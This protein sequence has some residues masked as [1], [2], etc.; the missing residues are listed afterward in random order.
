VSDVIDSGVIEVALDLS[1][2]DKQLANLSN[3]ISESVEQGFSNTGQAASKMASGLQNGVK[4]IGQQLNAAMA[5]VGVAAGG[6][7]AT[8]LYRGY[9]RYTTIEDSLISMET[10]LGSATRAATMLDDVLDVVRGTPFN[11]DQFADAASRMVAFGAEAEKIP[12]YLEAIGEVS[13]TKG[14]RANEFAMRLSTSFG[15][16]AAMGRISNEELNQM[17]QAGVPALRILANEAEVTTVE[18]KEMISQ[19]I[20]PADEAMDTLTKGILEGSNGLAGATPAMAGTMEGLRDTMTGALGGMQSAMARFGAEIVSQL[21]PG[22][23]A[24]F[25]ATAAVW[26]KLTSSIEGFSLDESSLM[27]TIVEFLEK[28]A[29]SD[30]GALDDIFDTLSSISSLAAPLAAMSGAKGLGAIAG[31]IPGLGALVGPLTG[32]IGTLVIGLGALLA[33]NEEFMA[34]LSDMGSQLMD[35]FAPL[36]ETVMGPLVDLM[37]VLSDTLAALIQAAVPLI[38]SLLIVLKPILDIVIDIVGGVLQGLTPAFEMVGA[39]FQRIAP[40]FQKLA[41]S[42]SELAEFAG[43]LITEVMNQ[44]VVQFELMMP[45]AEQLWVLIIELGAALIDMMVAL[46]PIVIELIAIQTEMMSAVLNSKEF[47]AA[48][49]FVTWTV[50]GL[51]KAAKWAAD[52]L[53]WISDKLNLGP[54]EEEVDAMNAAAEATR[55]AAAAQEELADRIG[56]VTEAIGKSLTPTEAWKASL[57]DSALAYKIFQEDLAFMGPSPL[58]ETAPKNFVELADAIDG[59]NLGNMAY[60]LERGE[61][62]LAQLEQQMIDNG[63]PAAEMQFAMDALGSAVGIAAE[64]IDSTDFGARQAEDARAAVNKFNEELVLFLDQ[65]EGIK[66]ASFG[67]AIASEFATGESSMLSMQLAA[68]DTQDV[69]DNF[70]GALEDVGGW[71]PDGTTFDATRDGAR[72]LYEAAI[73]LQQMF[74]EDLMEAYD[75]ANA[76]PLVDGLEAAQAA[77]EEFGAEM[78][79]GL[80]IEEGTAEYE[81]FLGVLGATPKQV[82]TM[83]NVAGEI[84]AEKKL[85]LL[86]DVIGGLPTDIQQ[87]ITAQ[88]MEDDYAGALE[89]AEKAV[90][91]GVDTPIIPLTPEVDEVVE[92]MTAKFLANPP[93]VPVF[94]VE[95]TDQYGEVSV[96]IK[97][98]IGEPQIT[99]R[100]NYVQGNGTNLLDRTTRNMTVGTSDVGAMGV[101]TMSDIDYTITGTGMGRE[102]NMVKIEDAT[103]MDGIDLD[104]L[105]AQVRLGMVLA[106]ESV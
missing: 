9:Q 106:G 86:G 90:A 102:V 13:A 63:V 29:N 3:E 100:L 72:E 44:M 64:E 56:L 51:V 41:D 95:P 88:I 18:M 55:A 78:A 79:A 6:A 5:A 92:E 26:D 60:N 53:G 93:D 36:M 96:A 47:A 38:Q 22:L 48:V 39:M 42:L 54:D 77:A 8:S 17:A 57:E 27:K 45:F 66:S 69:F 20:I 46:A 65:L 104:E 89:T 59:L 37:D 24:V 23:T 32:G 82:E 75:A 16:I 31:F 12:G 103:F 99:V 40:S 68:W 10:Q 7:L 87:T 98:G 101:G 81:E 33:T 14:G 52:A 11:L 94:I 76:D 74:G 30:T 62:G 49:E 61:D 4:K 85:D 70:K 2:I 34:S 80:G 1:S 15:Q 105:A 67:E 73:P 28:I 43:P 97:D 50:E 84:E 83:I 91:D 21:A 19:G 71:A 25:N 58:W 35:A